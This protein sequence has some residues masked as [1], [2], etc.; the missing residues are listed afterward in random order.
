MPTYDPIGD[1]VAREFM[2]RLVRQRR[3][4]LRAASGLPAVDLPLELPAG[5]RERFREA[6]DW[7]TMQ[8]HIGAMAA[9]L[10]SPDTNAEGA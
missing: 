3:S 4:Y 10:E 7:Q 5:W 6:T 1:P 2:A 8:D 9:E